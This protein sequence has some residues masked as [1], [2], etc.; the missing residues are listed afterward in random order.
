MA[1]VYDSLN[2]ILELLSGD[3]VRRYMADPEY[4]SFER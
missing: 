1:E 3:Y 2:T 4:V